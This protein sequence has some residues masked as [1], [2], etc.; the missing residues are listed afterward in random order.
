MDRGEPEN[1]MR[2]TLV[3]IVIEFGCPEVQTAEHIANDIMTNRR[4]IFADDYKQERHTLLSWLLPK[5]G[6]VA[7]DANLEDLIAE[8]EKEWTEP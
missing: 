5:L 8:I 7:P 6:V 4:A 3:D 2:A 1:T